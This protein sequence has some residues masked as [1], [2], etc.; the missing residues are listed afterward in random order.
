[1]VIWFSPCQETPV[2]SNL[3]LNTFSDVM[4]S[5]GGGG[6]MGRGLTISVQFSSVAQSCLTLCDPMDL[7]MPDLPVQHQL[8][9]STQTHVH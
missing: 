2:P 1:M 8:P 3:S 9:E 4:G 5:L 7:S 6:G